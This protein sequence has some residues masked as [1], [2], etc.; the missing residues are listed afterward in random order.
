[1]HYPYENLKDLTLSSFIDRAV[2]LHSQNQ[3]FAYVGEKPFNYLEFGNKVQNMVKLLQESGIKK[4]DKVMLL[5]E[6]MPHWAVAYFAT[7]YFGAVIVP[8]LTDFHKEDIH[9]ILEHSQA[10][11]VFVS[12]KFEKTI[13]DSQINELKIA[14]NLDKLILIDELSDKIYL[15]QED[16]NYEQTKPKEDDLATI[17]YTSGTTGNSKGVMLSHKNLITNTLST[18]EK[19][20]INQDDIFLSI[21]PL[22]HTFECTTGM[23]LPILNGASVHYIKKPPTPSILMK[24]LSSVKPTVIISVPLIIEKIYKSKVLPTFTNSLIMRILYKI[25]F[26]RKRLN[27]LAGSKLLESFG[28]KLKIFGIGGAPLSPYVEKFLNEA[29]FPYMVGYGLTETA[30]LLT[31]G[32][33]TEKQKIKS[34]GTSFYGVEIKIKNPNPKT[35][36]GE[37]MARSPSVMMGYYKNEKQTAEVMEDDWFLTGDLGYLD[38]DGY[39]FI[40]GRSKNVIL[41]SSGENIYPEQIESLINK[42]EDILDS[43]MMMSDSKL[44]ARIH[45]DYERFADDITQEEIEDILEK[46]RVKINSQ[47]SSFSKMNKFIEQKEEFIKTPTKKI[48]RYLYAN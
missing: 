11:A 17:I 9:R 21:L 48:K 31:A 18:F 22:A 35:G 20:D 12:K 30:P 6:N 16:K 33:F 3:L 44:I 4:D 28:G 34:A 32:I 7:T 10:K 5:S 36:E 14:I 8:V 19:I 43:L 47:L 26:I 46:K 24:A 39:L 29:K 15:S 2:S 40:S 13:K 45:L 37:I 27:I 41:G 38:K 25:P 42:D 1:M 23:L